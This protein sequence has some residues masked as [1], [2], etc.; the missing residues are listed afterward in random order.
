LTEQVPQVA[1]ALDTWH[2]PLIGQYFMKRLKVLS[3]HG[4]SATSV[5][6]M[7][8]LE[9]RGYHHVFDEPDSD[10][11]VLTWPRTLPLRE[12]DRGW[13]DLETIQRRLPELAEIPTV[14]LWAPEDE[15]FQIETANRL[16]ELLSHAEGPILFDRAP[17]PAGRIVA[18]IWPAPPSNS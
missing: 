13:R 14:L 16:K 11:V 3:Q 7:S 5:R 9:A 4:P 12:G 8:E 1:Q 10:Y 17:L 6:G 18:R 2:A 15:V